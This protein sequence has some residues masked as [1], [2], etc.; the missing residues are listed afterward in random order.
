MDDGT[1]VVV[2]ETFYMD[3]TAVCFCADILWYL[4]CA[5]A[6]VTWNKIPVARWLDNMAGLYHTNPDHGLFA[7]DPVPEEDNTAFIIET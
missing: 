3:G 2:N 4:H 6:F 1:E 5:Y 7:R